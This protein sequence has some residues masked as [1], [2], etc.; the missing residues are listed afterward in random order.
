MVL[1]DMFR[2]ALGLGFRFR[3]LGTERHVSRR[4]RFRV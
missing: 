3:V 4:F 1:K 2:A